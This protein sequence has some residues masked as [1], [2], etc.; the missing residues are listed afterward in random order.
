MFIFGSAHVAGF[1]VVL[2]DGSVHLVDY[3]IDAEVHRRSG[4]RK[5]ELP[6]KI[7]Q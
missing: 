3:T 6:V 7:G 2:C 4:N 1:Q 5:E